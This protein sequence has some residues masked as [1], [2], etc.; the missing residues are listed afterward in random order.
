MSTVRS[1]NIAGGGDIVTSIIGQL[2]ASSLFNTNAKS[3]RASPLLSRHALRENGC[4]RY[5]VPWTFHHWISC[6]R[7]KLGSSHLRSTSWCVRR[8]LHGTSSVRRWVKHFKDGNTDIADQPRCGLQ[9]TAATGRKK[10]KSR[11]THQTRPKDNIQRNC[12]TAWSGAPCGPAHDGHFWDIGKVC[13]CWVPRFLTGTEEHKM[14]GNCSPIHPT[15]RIWPPQTTTCLGPWKITWAVTTTRLTRQSRKPWE[16]GCEEL[17]RTS[18]AEAILRFCNAGRNA[19]IG[20]EI[21]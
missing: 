13:S 10:Q 9:R 11:R 15:V 5:V 4:I 3:A 1:G 19:Q 17:E 16:A 6:E 12:S 14:A 7:G 2:V 20:M 8:C 18:T 21:L